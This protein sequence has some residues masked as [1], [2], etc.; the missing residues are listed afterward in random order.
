MK[1][2]CKAKHKNYWHYR[3]VYRKIAGESHF[4]IV[5]CHGK[6]GY[7]EAFVEFESKAALRDA[8]LGMLVDT[9]RFRDCEVNTSPDDYA[10]FQGEPN[11]GGKP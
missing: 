4:R 11:T 2:R 5:E 3:V 1:Y 8:L 9:Y 10:S 6:F 7:G